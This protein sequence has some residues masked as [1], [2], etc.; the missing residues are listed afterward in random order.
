VDIIAEIPAMRQPATRGFTDNWESIVTP[1]ILVILDILD[2][3]LL[4]PTLEEKNLMVNE[5]F[6]PVHDDPDVPA[7]YS[8]LLKRILHHEDVFRRIEGAIHAFET[9]LKVAE[10]S[11]HPDAQLARN[12]LT[13][14]QRL[15]A[16]C[17]ETPGAHFVPYALAAVDYL[18]TEMDNTP[19]FGKDGG[20]NDDAHVLEAVL[21]HFDLKRKM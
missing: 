16:L 5:H 14:A 1:C 11:G 7:G 12:L 10:R 18:V 17:Q 4:N 8:K 15:I 20:F 2:S 6:V 13:R 9:R 19:D 21:N 3:L